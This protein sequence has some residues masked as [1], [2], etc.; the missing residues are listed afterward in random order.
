MSECRVE[1]IPGDANVHIIDKPA[2]ARTYRSVVGAL[3]HAAQWK[4]PDIAH[5]V[6]MVSRYMELPSGSQMNAATNKKN[7]FRY[8]RGAARDG[9]NEMEWLRQLLGIRESIA[10]KGKKTEWANTDAQLGDIRKK[11][12]VKTT[13]FSLKKR[14]MEKLLE[15][16]S[17]N[18]K[19][20]ALL[21]HQQDE[22]N[23]GQQNPGTQVS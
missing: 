7:V 11:S 23:A 21:D 2:N 12:L 20:E 1:S 4:R 6:N 16:I 18:K 14:H 8:L 19:S 13:L 22:C 3:N 17:N 9:V 15:S 10:N 5:A